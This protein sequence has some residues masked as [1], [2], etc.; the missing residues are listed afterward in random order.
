MYT[1]SR[2]GGQGPLSRL[3]GAHSLAMSQFTAQRGVASLPLVQTAHRLRHVLRQDRIQSRRRSEQALLALLVD[4]HQPGAGEDPATHGPRPTTGRCWPVTSMP[5]SPIRNSVQAVGM[6]C[7]SPRAGAPVVQDALAVHRLRA[8]AS[9]A[10]GSG[11]AGGSTAR[12][13]RNQ[14]NRR[15]LRFHAI[16]FIRRFHERFGMSPALYRAGRCGRVAARW[17]AVAQVRGGFHEKRRGARDDAEERQ[18][19]A[20][21]RMLP[22]F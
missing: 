19:D 6:C 7:A 14:G 21:G 18:V 12:S 3:L 13:R 4:L 10:A 17:S 15:V 1:D 16:H 22:N 20:H 8:R 11:G 2:I 9:L 5:I